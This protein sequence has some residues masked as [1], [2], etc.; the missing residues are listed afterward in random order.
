MP[1]PRK[2]RKGVRTVCDRVE[3]VL[4]R[5]DED[6]VMRQLSACARSE[7]ESLIQCL[8]RVS[9]LSVGGSSVAECVETVEAAL[10]E[11]ARCSDA[12]LGAGELLKSAESEDRMRGLEVLRGLE[13]V[14]LDEAVSSEVSAASMVL[15]MGRDAN[16]GNG[17]RTAA[18][19]SAFALCFRNLSLIH[20]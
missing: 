11:L 13:R 5:F 17:E 4:D 18:W 20:I 19:M 16:R 12:V 3:A 7:L 8:C 2:Q 1:S 14:V 10:H 9:G 15:D 6:G